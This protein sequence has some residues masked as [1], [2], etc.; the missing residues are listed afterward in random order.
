MNEPEQT[1]PIAAADGVEP[2]PSLS[3]LRAAHAQ[4][5]QRH[6]E[7]GEPP[8][9]LEEVEVFIE[10][11][12][13]TGALLDVEDDRWASQGLLDFWVAVLYR[14][15]REPPDATL[16]DFDPTLA[17]ELADTDC[18]YVGLDAFG[19][20][21]HQIFFGRQRVVQKMLGWL[22]SWL[23][24]K[25]LLAVVG[26][27]GS[28]KSSLALAGLLPS[29]RSGALPESEDWRYFPSM[30]PGSNPL[31]NLA[32]LLLPA[33]ADA[34]A[35]VQR[36]V[37][38]FQ[39]DSGHLAQLIGH[40]QDRPAVLVI[41]QFEE[42][43]TL[44]DDLQ[45]REAFCANLLE[46]VQAP[47]EDHIVILTMRADFEPHV[48]ALPEFHRFFE[49]A[50]LRVPPLSPVELR[51]AIERPA[52]LVGLRFE[53]GVVDA[54]LQDILGEPAALPLLQFTLLKLWEMR[55]RNRVTWEAYRRLGGGR[56]ALANVADEFYDGLIP[57]DQTAA[58]YILLRMVR[59]G[60]GLEVTSNRIRRKALYQAGPAPYL[61]DGVLNKLLEAR[62]VRL[63]EGDTPDDSQVEVAHE[64]LVRNWPR[65]VTWLDEERVTMVTR[66]RLEAK[67]AEWVRLGRGNAGLL[68]QVQLLEAK[69]WLESPDA[70]RLGY[71]EDLPALVQASQEAIRRANQEREA[72]R[73]RQIR[74]A[75]ALAQAEQ[76]RAAA[77]AQSAG[78]LRWL[79]VALTVV[80]IL[81]LGAAAFAFYAKQ[82]A[83]SHALEA[84][85]QAA[86]AV[87]ALQIA[88]EERQNADQQAATAAVAEQVAVDERQNADAQAATAVVA[89]VMAETAAADA[90]AKQEVAQDT[91]A[92]QEAQIL[93][94]LQ[95]PATEAVVIVTG[96]PP[97]TST[98]EVTPEPTPTATTSPTPSPS[99]DPTETIQALATQLHYVRATQTAVAIQPLSGEALTQMTEDSYDEY[100]PTLSPDQRTLLVESN[101]TGDWHIFSMDPDGKNWRQLTRQGTNYHARFSPDGARIVFASNMEGDRDIYTMAPDGSDLQRL[102]EA[103]GDD[104]YPSY[105]ADGKLIVFM[106]K[107]GGTWGVYAMEADGSQERVLFDTEHDDLF[108]SISPDGEWIVFQ[109]NMKVNWEIFIVS[110]DGGEPRQLTVDRARDANPVF[111]P[112]GRSIVFETSRD[113]NYEIYVMD[114]DGSNPRNLT[115]S[116]SAD[117]VPSVSPDGQWVIFQ[118]KRSGNWDVYRVPLP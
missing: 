46:L 101:R 30:V 66:R 38:R 5:L 115:N 81:A 95:P 87:A 104:S 45:I 53:E 88:D 79:V 22:K 97:P 54:L 17:P 59:P 20:A 26:P 78:R 51:E 71:R 117:M 73:Q 64:A 109:S 114:V 13:A 65:L 39:E 6:F 90:A 85:A 14:T 11:G 40:E 56:Q 69:T 100:V 111:S 118:S 8:E 24:E 102:T 35:W 2:F 80:I 32:G 116:P 29:L 27:S 74:Q 77:E 98:G 60:E 76:Q 93:D 55:E 84:E 63:I 70:Q 72:E 112:D 44:C 16:A 113:G 92:T 41:D 7:L 91:L 68:D 1:V 103:V 3:S 28:G 94:Q 21:E 82:T 42:I 89:Q 86:T 47:P 61:I 107:R 33:G 108:P 10:R 18:P 31:A 37:A 50:M 9:L 67:A 105:S 110:I 83:D 58:R 34:A 52:E 96:T 43:F 12:R 48:A 75:H 99:P 19:E 62:L 4:L 49:R 36:Q 15:D 25:R 23:K 57:E 106:S